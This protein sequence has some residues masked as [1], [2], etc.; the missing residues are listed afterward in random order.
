MRF[1]Q[2]GELEGDKI[3][4][5]ITLRVAANEPTDPVSLSFFQKLLGLTRENVFHDGS[6]SPLEVAAEGYTSPAG[7][8]VYEWKS[9]T[10][11]KI[12]AVNLTAGA[13]QGRVRLGDRVSATQQYI[14]YDQLNEVRYDRAGDEL[15]NVG[16]FVRLEGFQAHIFSITPA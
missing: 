1:Y 3:H 6:W 13:S 12:I 14:F 9:R 15:H 10:A 4:L 11:W 8:I 16:L 7:L 2:Q 5:P